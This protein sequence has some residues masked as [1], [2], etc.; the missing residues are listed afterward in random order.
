ML[1]P[2]CHSLNLSNLLPLDINYDEDDVCTANI[3]I[4]DGFSHHPSFPS[5][6]LSSENGCTLC[7]LIARVLQEKQT[8]SNEDRLYGSILGESEDALVARLMTESS[9]R[10]Y[11]YRVEGTE[12]QDGAGIWEMGVV[13]TF[14]YGERVGGVGGGKGKVRKVDA[15]FWRALEVWGKD[16]GLISCLI[17]IIFA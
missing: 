9:G 7:T 4:F 5:L 1:C 2:L 16:G 14:D 11:L 6:L 10:V 17:G 8:W 12:K 13:A 15:F 3:N